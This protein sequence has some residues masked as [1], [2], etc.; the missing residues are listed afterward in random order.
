MKFTFPDK[1]ILKPKQPVLIVRDAKAFEKA[2]GKTVLLLGTFDGR[3]KN[4]GDRLR[5]VDS[6]GDA[7]TDVRYT[8]RSPWPE[9]TKD[10][11]ASLQR[12]DLKRNV[13][14][15]INWFAAPPT[16]G[17]TS[18]TPMKRSNDPSFYQ[19][20]HSPDQPDPGKTTTISAWLVLGESQDT[21]LTMHVDVNGKRFEGSCVVKADKDTSSYEIR[22]KVSKLPAP[23]LVHYWFTLGNSD[24]K[25]TTRFP[26]SGEPVPAFFLQTSKKIAESR[27]PLYQLWLDDEIWQSVQRNARGDETQWATFVYNQKAYPVRV[28]CRGAFARSWP[29]KSFKIWP[30]VRLAGWFRLPL[31]G[32]RAQ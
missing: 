4:G 8:A 19:I 17:E 14:D 28:R 25:A 30:S 6:E 10:G 7:V 18:K 3:L 16:P 27:L 12:V 9:I 2:F 5:I 29:K 24:T 31:E 15:P 22:A 21:Q 1:T 11:S 23:S 26:Q 20:R 32:D 13:D